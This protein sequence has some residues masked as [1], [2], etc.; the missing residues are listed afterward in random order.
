MRDELNG[1]HLAR[2]DINDIKLIV[3]DY[4]S[5][6]NFRLLKFLIEELGT[7]TDKQKFEQYEKEFNEYAKRRIFE[8]S[9]ELGEP[10][11]GT[12]Q[13]NIIIKLDHHYNQCALNQ[14]K[15][16]EA[17][18]CK[19]LNI[20]NLKLCLIAAGC[21]QLTFQVPWFVKREIFPVSEEQ[22]EM[23]AALHVIRVTCGYY[24]YLDRVTVR[25]LIH[26]IVTY[27][28]LILLVFLTAGN[29][30]TF[31]E[32]TEGEHSKS[33]TGENI[34]TRSGQVKATFFSYMYVNQT[35]NAW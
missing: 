21:L 31:P 6:F 20:T 30:N 17:D 2:A 1:L 14:L 11:N 33:N 26:C 3:L 34:Y 4:C 28:A 22:K 12:S 15:L 10:S 9:S 7:A 13:A 27:I 35:H 5:F 32:A 29:G 18:F 24:C 23:L 19:I 16:L 25:Q 8:C